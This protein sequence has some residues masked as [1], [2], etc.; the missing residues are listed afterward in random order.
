MDEGDLRRDLS[1]LL[2]HY[3]KNFHPEIYPD[4]SALCEAQRLLPPGI[5]RI[6]LALS[7]RYSGFPKHQFFRFIECLRPHDDYPSIF[8]RISPFPPPPAPKP[9]QILNPL[10]HITCHF[11]AIY[12]LVTDPLRRILVTGAD[13]CSIKLWT[14]PDLDPICRLAGHQ[15]PVT[16]C[17]INVCCTLLLSSSNDSTL[18]L[19]SLEDGRQLA[20]LAGFTANI[21]HYACFSPTGSMIA[22][23][24]EDGSIPLWITADALKNSPPVKV[25]WTP[26]KLAA[27]WVTFSPGGEFLAF[28]SEQC[29]VTV[30]ALKTLTQYNLEAFSGLVENL[31]FMSEYFTTGS[32]VGLR[33]IGSAPE[34]G[35]LLI[36]GAE[37][38]SWPQ[39]FV[40]KNVGPPGRRP[41]KLS[42]WGLDQNEHLLVLCKTHGTYVCD[43]VTGEVLGEMPKGGAFENCHC[44]AP[45]PV[46]PAIFFF[47]NHSGMVAIA[48]IVERV[49]LAEMKCADEAEFLDAFWSAD[50]EW[51][52]AAD[53]SG[54]ITSF[55]AFAANDP[56]RE[57]AAYVSCELFDSAQ[58]PIHAGAA[59]HF[60]DGTGKRVGFQPP[61]RDLRLLQ[62]PLDVLQQPLLCACATELRLIQKFSAGVAPAT[63][64]VSP[65]G[66]VAPPPLHIRIT[67]EGPVSPHGGS[68][69]STGDDA[70]DGAADAAV[71][72]V[73]DSDD[74]K[75]SDG[76]GG[77]I[78]DPDPGF[79]SDALMALTSNDVP[80]GLW[81]IWRAVVVWDDRFY[82]PQVGDAVTIIWPA[83]SI[84][85]KHS[86]IPDPG[87]HNGELSEGVIRAISIEG[88][89][90]SVSVSMADDRK[91]GVMFRLPEEIEWL[92]P[93]KRIERAVKIAKTIKPGDM[94]TVLRLHENWAV[95]CLQYRTVEVVKGK[96]Y[97]AIHATNSEG[98][99]VR[100]SPWSI[101]AINGLVCW[102]PEPALKI[103]KNRSEFAKALS[104]VIGNADNAECVHVFGLDNPEFVAQ[105][106]WPMSLTMIKDRMEAGYYRSIEAIE[107]D[108]K[109]LYRNRVLYH[110]GDTAIVEQT[111][112]L[113]DRL[114]HALRSSAPNR[115]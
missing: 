8:R 76:S 87:P 21:I 110:R 68:E 65:S 72:F 7:L 61:A 108:I 100:L 106:D 23:A 54:A 28:S 18:R 16:N 5:D 74:W 59:R 73:S 15:G 20:V 2:L 81:P 62:L 98:F 102:A 53:D 114:I 35:G 51:I 44:V 67:V 90:L 80:A 75:F 24:C 17:C 86:G 19:W 83:Y 92:V 107:A 60:C 12:C 115:K 22:A 43:A 3:L 78:E 88:G 25:L 66:T 36:W 1:I 93:T 47:G 85:I 29:H 99:V 4:F 97:Q 82:F 50:G 103:N 38:G 95:E 55:R 34:D 101:G 42:G 27:A 89:Y 52:F 79:F 105:L 58:F 32:D 14:L 33:L 94:L 39:K 11:S 49:V 48:D 26:H 104:S 46:F 112:A 70:G 56:Q 30:V 6:D 9:F 109:V 64:S 41:T 40:F 77:E 71:Q 96:G 91:V 37:A 84:A 13:D 63:M 57:L 10:K 111:R 113:R 45:N 31:R 69:E